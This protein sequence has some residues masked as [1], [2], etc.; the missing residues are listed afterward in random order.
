MRSGGI[1]RMGEFLNSSPVW[2]IHLTDDTG[3]TGRAAI[4]RTARPRRRENREEHHAERRANLS[5]AALSS[6]LL[7]G[8]R[9]HAIPIGA[10][11]PGTAW[12]VRV[13]SRV[14][15][16]QAVRLVGS[17]CDTSGRSWETQ[18]W[19]EFSMTGGIGLVARTSGRF[20]PGVLWLVG[21]PVQGP[22]SCN[23]TAHSST[24]LRMSRP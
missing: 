6:F 23:H 24:A 14:A 20:S 21:H 2:W 7:Q 17:T 3:L 5:W 16:R 22:T 13:S 15:R 12:R 9:D 4:G 8:D 19:L 1:T 11:M 10:R 18:A